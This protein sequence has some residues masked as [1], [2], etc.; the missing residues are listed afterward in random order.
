MHLSSQQN[1]SNCSAAPHSIFIFSIAAAG[2]AAAGVAA[3]PIAFVYILSTKE[4]ALN[5][6]RKCSD[7]IFANAPK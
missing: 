6:I 7:T 3:A 4:N 2:I 1:T 5:G